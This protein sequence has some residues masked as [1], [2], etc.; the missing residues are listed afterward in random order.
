M[1]LTRALLCPQIAAFLARAADIALAIQAEK[2]GKLKDFLEGLA[3]SKEAATLRT[4][5]EAFSAGFPM[6]GFTAASIGI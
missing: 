6:P 5:V 4:E 2:G 1:G 3:M